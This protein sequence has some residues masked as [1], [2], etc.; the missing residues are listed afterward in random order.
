[1]KIVTTFKNKTKLKKEQQNQQKR[2]KSGSYHTALE[3]LID[4][5]Q[6]E[7]Y[8][9]FFIVCFVLCKQDIALNT[10]LN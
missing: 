3:V 5:D 10:F 2:E 1:M 8:H 9:N 7:E 6:E 4:V